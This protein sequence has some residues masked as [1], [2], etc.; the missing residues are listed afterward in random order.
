MP[1]RIFSTSTMCPAATRPMRSKMADPQQRLAIRSWIELARYIAYP[2]QHSLT[3]VLSGRA[4]RPCLGGLYNPLRGQN[5]RA[6]LLH[7]RAAADTGDVRI[8]LGSPDGSHPTSAP[9]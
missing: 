6:H 7:L 9:L 5:L 1:I 4:P 3:P 2:S 8:M